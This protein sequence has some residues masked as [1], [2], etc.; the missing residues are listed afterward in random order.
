MSLIKNG[1]DIGLRWWDEK[2]FT[3]LDARI[4][5]IEEKLSKVRQRTNYGFS[6][7]DKSANHIK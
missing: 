2:K 4:L 3:F 1:R 7:K 5:D 6:E